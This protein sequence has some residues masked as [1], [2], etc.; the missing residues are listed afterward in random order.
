[1]KKDELKKKEKKEKKPILK[2]SLKDKNRIIESVYNKKKYK[3]EYVFL[4]NGSIT[5]TDNYK[6]K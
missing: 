5:K 1:M 2:V 6:L 3:T 4:E